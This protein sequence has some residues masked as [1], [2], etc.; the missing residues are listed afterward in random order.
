MVGRRTPEQ[1]VAGVRSSIRSPCCIH[2]Q[3]IFTSLKVL[4]IPRKRW[5]RP[6]MTGKMLTGALSLNQAKQKLYSYKTKGK[7][8]L[9]VDK[10]VVII[11]VDVCP[12]ILNITETSPYKSYP[13]F[14]P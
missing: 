8:T 5:L 1:E 11:A 7:K 14:A 12:R 4:A 10:F 2:E 9:L 13:R 6:D 3:D